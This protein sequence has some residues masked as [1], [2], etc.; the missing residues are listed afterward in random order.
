MFVGREAD[1]EEL[2]R[3]WRKRVASL[4]TC[5]GRRRIGKSTL[6]EEFARRSGARFLKLE[7]KA[8][9]PGMSNKVQLATFIEQ[10][11][12]QTKTRVRSLANWSEAFAALDAELD[13]AKTVVLL[14]EISWMGKYDVGFPG[15]LKIAWDNLFKK[16]DR[17]IVFLC[18]SVS[19]WIAKNIL[20]NT[21][22]VGRA[23]CNFVVRELP[24]D[25]CV[26]FWGR[27]AARTATRDIVD[28]LSVTGGVPRYL[29]E[30]DPSLS[31]DENVRRM[32][33]L[34]QALLRDDFT[35]IFNVVFGENAVTKRTILERLSECPLTVAE[36]AEALGVER[37]GTISTHLED[38]EVAGFVSEDAGLVPGTDRT[39]KQMRY[40]VCDNYTRFFLK[41]IQ[42][43]ARTIDSGSFRFNALETLKG[44][45]TML[46]LQFEN[47][48]IANLPRLLPA[49]GMGNVLLKSAAP[50]RQSATRRR[51]GC[52]IDLLL[53]ADRKVCVVE[54]KRRATI[55]RE[56]IDEV[57]SKVRSLS[58]PAGVSVRTALVYEGTLAK[59]VE[60]EGYFDA[61]VPVESLMYGSEKELA[62]GRR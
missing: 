37:S 28:V 48:V 36:I 21:G 53:Q 51:K 26:K 39:P 50:Y 17:T 15:E 8:P 38:L 19:T 43:N 34:P 58:L 12:R 33:F 10:L 45:E 20:N 56:V 22:F 1:L 61:L 40:R 27:K 42:P 62:F 25:A 54:I 35:K 3:L 14:D 9:E 55:G 44:W 32:C 7:G 6:I 60:A 47:L 57:E 23:S 41:Y 46:G 29:E 5:R 59:S 30:I 24:L 2:S 52:Q 4:V 16:H 31:A 18:G 49:L 13:A 11:R